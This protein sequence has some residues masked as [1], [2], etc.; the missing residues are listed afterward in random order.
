MGQNVTG[1]TKIKYEANSNVPIEYIFHDLKGHVRFP[2]TPANED[3]GIKVNK[4]VNR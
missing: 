2:P 1:S 4:L 3:E